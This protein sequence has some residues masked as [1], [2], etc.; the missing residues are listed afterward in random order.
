[1]LSEQLKRNKRISKSKKK[2]CNKIYQS[3][4]YDAA[5]AC[6]VGESDSDE[7]APDALRLLYSTDESSSESEEESSEESVSSPISNGLRKKKVD[8]FLKK[9]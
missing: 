6:R 8:E 2:I 7:S 1:M 3:Q 9:E 4:R 5:S